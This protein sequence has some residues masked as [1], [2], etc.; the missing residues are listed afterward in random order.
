MHPDHEAALAIL[1]SWAPDPRTGLPYELFL[2][3]SHLVP[4]INVDLLISDEQGR[5]L[6]T[7]RDDEIHGAGWHVPGGMIRFK[8]TAEERVRTTAL[9]ELGAEVTF[10]ATPVIEQMIE[11]EREVRGHYVSLIYRCRLISGPA[12][13]LQF[14]GGQPERGQWAW[15]ARYPE[16]MIAAHKRYSR[17][18]KS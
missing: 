5:I 7:W 4:M 18:F 10:D 3:V 1:N 8:E 17:F 16:N 9:D 14:T 12:E 11:P 2:F 13:S 6:L 15:H